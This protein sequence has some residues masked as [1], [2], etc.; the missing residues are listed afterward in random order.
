MLISCQTKREECLHAAEQFQLGEM[1]GMETG[2][3]SD[4]EVPCW[5]YR[6]P[7]PLPPVH[8]VQHHLC[9]AACIPVEPE[10]EF[11]GI[12]PVPAGH[13]KIEGGV[14]L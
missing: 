3:G 10:E 8:S 14:L 13:R 12:V 5:S 1:V 4:G 7:R 6:V 2:G 11:S 9:T